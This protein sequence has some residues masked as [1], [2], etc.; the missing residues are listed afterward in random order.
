VNSLQSIELAHDPAVPQ[1]DHLLDLDAMAR[2]FSL[3][4]G[5]RGPVT[6]GSCRRECV[7]YRVGK[8]LRV[9]Y[10]VDIHGRDQRIVAST[11]RSRKRSERAFRT[12]TESGVEAG[13]LRPALHD[14][15]LNVVYRTFPND[16]RIE[17]LA[18]VADADADM[19]R[20]VDRRWTKSRLIDYYPE[21]SAV[22]RCLDDDG[23]TIGYAKVH[24][25]DEGHRTF[26]MQEAL[27]EAARA[28]G[29][30]IAR[31]LAY[32][33]QHRTLMVEAIAGPTI[34]DLR[35]GELLAGLHAYGVA[36]ATLHSLPPV[37]FAVPV[38]SA[39]ERLEE[40]AEGM[41]AVLPDSVTSVTVFL[42]ELR[43]RWDET[44]GDPV[45]VH[46]DTNQNNAILQEDRVAFIDFDRA[47][48]GLAASDIGNFL[49]LLRYFRSLGLISPGAE[50]TRTA[51]FLDGYSS[52]RPLPPP[53][54]LC[55]HE[56]AA[57]AER[58]SRAITRLHGLALPRVPALLSEALSLLHSR[59]R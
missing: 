39:L 58:A 48:I 6:I 2:R 37:D 25:G 22:V 49:G 56:A 7:S 45:P 5:S 14:A 28:S 1:R 57:V 38:D 54:S 9:V 3:H 12:A 30:R 17:H 44:A 15:E 51:V 26:R 27:W 42:E 50:S 34:G 16:R 8:R 59:S 52:V 24:A 13:Q 36:L 32:S 40:R 21:A 19:T 35:G 47:T 41:C 31:P 46:G 10:R 23:R 55:V 33:M 29:L 53:E 18:A 43:A 20:S 11:F 4:I